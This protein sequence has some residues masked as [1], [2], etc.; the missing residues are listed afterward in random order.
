M[1]RLLDLC[2]FHLPKNASVTNKE[3]EAQ[4][5]FS[6]RLLSNLTVLLALIDFKVF[7]SDP[8]YLG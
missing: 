2:E 1:S 3:V 8:A 6:P 5:R 7:L 4:E